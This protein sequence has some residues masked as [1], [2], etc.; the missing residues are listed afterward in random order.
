M[1]KREKLVKA[2]KHEL[3]LTL[4][5]RPAAVEAAC[6][7][8]RFVLGKCNLLPMCFAVEILARECLNN[9]IEHGSVHRPGAEVSLVMKIGA[10]QVCLRVADQGPGFPWRR[11]YRRG[12]PSPH[13]PGGRG[14]MVLRTYAQ[15]IAFNAKGNAVTLWIN[16]TERDR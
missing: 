9:A 4:P 2:E 6:R 7:Q 14:L 15:R 8:L 16:R 3:R 1:R 5:A 13:R 11:L 10:K 12:W